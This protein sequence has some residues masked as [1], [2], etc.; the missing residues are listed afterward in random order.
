MAYAFNLD[1]LNILSIHVKKSFKSSTWIYRDIQD[2]QDKIDNLALGQLDADQI[3]WTLIKLNPRTFIHRD[4][5]DE[6]DNGLKSKPPKHG[7]WLEPK[8]EF[9]TSAF[10]FILYI[11]RIPVKKQLR[12]FSTIQAGFQNFQNN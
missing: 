9:E 4:M 1:I 11:L 7:L 12:A 2:E 5:Q 3:W 6:Q 10:P 8:T